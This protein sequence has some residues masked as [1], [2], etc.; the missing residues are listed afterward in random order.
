MGFSID[1][2]REFLPQLLSGAL[3]TI[4]LTV[5]SIILAVILGLTVAIVRLSR[6]TIATVPA[7]LFVDVMR[8]TPLLLQIFYIYYVL[9]LIGIELDSFLAGIIAL[10]LNY[11]AY[12]SEVFR[13]GIQAV[14]SGQREAAWSLGLPARKTMRQIILPQAIRIVIPSVG[15]YFIALFKDSALVSVIALNELL[16]A[17]QL[18]AAQTYKHY[19]IYTLV[20]LIYLAISYPATWLVQ[21]AERVF[22]IGRPK[23]GATTGSTLVVPPI[24]GVTLNEEIPPTPI[25]IAKARLE[26]AVAGRVVVDIKGLSKSFGHFTVLKEVDLKVSLG[27]KIVICGPS[28]S[29]KSTLIRCINGLEPFQSGQLIV[30]GIP[31]DGDKRHIDQ[32]RTEVGMVFQSFNLFPHLT[33]LENCILSPITVRKLAR[34]DAEAIA[35][36]YLKRVRIHD[37]AHKFPA[38]LSGGQQQRV[39]IARALCMKPQIMLFDEPTSALDPEMVSEVLDVMVDLAN[40]GMTMICVTHEMGFARRVADRVVFVNEG[41]IV[42]QADP[43]TFFSSP[44]NERARLFLSQVLGH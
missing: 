30:D 40:Q 39:A 29:G 37:Q 14:P 42:E 21:W 6:R 17:G 15:N 36:E 20:A 34:E 12:L 24:S 18:L 11:A 5:I 25:P 32:I 7:A 4:E 23:R 43:E 19:E 3:I 16:R 33:V 38:Q 35:W 31:L 10:S 27:E 1:D 22:A 8:G 13:S 28:G 26:R 44:Q 9:P 41:K 2:I